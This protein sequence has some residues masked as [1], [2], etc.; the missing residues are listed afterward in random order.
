MPSTHGLCRMGENLGVYMKGAFLC[1]IVVATLLI[2]AGSG[3]GDAESPSFKRIAKERTI[4]VLDPSTFIGESFVVSPDGRRAAFIEKVG[5]KRTAVVDGVRQRPYDEIS[6]PLVG[7]GLEFSPDSSRITYFAREDKDWFLVI[8]GQ[9]QRE[10]RLNIRSS[11]L[12]GEVVYS[13]LSMIRYSK[14]GAHYCYVAEEGDTQYLVVDGKAFGNRY[15]EVYSCTFSDDGKRIAYGAREKGGEKIFYVIDGVKQKEY[16]VTGHFTFSPDGR[17]FG[18]TAYPIKAWSRRGQREFV[19]LDGIEQRER[20]YYE[21]SPVTFSPDGKRAVYWAEPGKAPA[22]KGVIV[23]DGREI[24]DERAGLGS[25]VFSPDS[26]RIAYSAGVSVPPTFFRQNPPPPYEYQVVDGKGGKPYE[27]VSLAVF[28]PD[29]RRVAYYGRN[30]KKYRMVID[31]EE[32]KAYDHTGHPVFSPDSKRI[33]YQARRGSDYFIV[34]DGR[35][36]SGYEFVSNPVFS[37]DGTRV[38]YV[39][40]QSGKRTVVIDEREGPFYDEI[41]PRRWQ[42]RVAHTGIGFSSDLGFHYFA[43]KGNEL[44]FVQETIV[45]T[46]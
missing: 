12:L 27:G 17:R 6:R 13:R 41:Y 45:S 39:A 15:E 40:T 25:F 42:H 30:Q 26:T 44:V 9:E 22:P 21:V 19:V 34:V 37:P 8:D 29:S 36:H 20:E 35:E 33:G 28:S 7:G 38:C 24:S 14:E 4:A 10:H 46:D 3:R 16:G 1:V 11:T 43:K 31:N 5:D 32:G 18:Y 23:L 2:L